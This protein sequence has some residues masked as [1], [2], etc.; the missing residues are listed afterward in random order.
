[1]TLPTNIGRYEIQ[2]ELGRGG[3]AVVYQA[4]DPMF[5]REVAVKV[6]LGAH[7]TAAIALQTRATMDN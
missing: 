6:L 1:M 4:H 3:M 2:K 5:D 7:L